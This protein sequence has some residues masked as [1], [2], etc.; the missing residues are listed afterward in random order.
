MSRSFRAE[1]AK[2][3]RRPATWLLLAI[4]LALSLIFTYLF[5]YAAVAGGTEGP[6]SDRGLPVL[7]P[8]HLVGNSLGG[9]PVFLGAIL[10]I[11]GVLTVGGE[12][13][14]GTWK[15]V[16]S[17]GPTRLEVYA[18]KLLALAAAAL[19]VVLAVFAVGAVSSLAI[20]SAEAQPVHW[21]T[22]GD[23]F[24]GLGAGWLIATMWAMLGAVLAVALRAVALP[25]GLG[26]VWML[27]VQNLLSA[28]A[29]PLLDW[30]AQAQKGLPGPNAG[31]LAAALGAPG[32][33]PGVAATVGGGQAA[34]VVA[35]YLVAFAAVGGVLL[36][37]RDI[38]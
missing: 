38:G 5:P 14:W 10:L 36:R 32:D 22:A 30:V 24:A 37:R 17:Q 20:A 31:A 29:A 33:T 7:L 21:P 15:T 18:G 19:A 3:V 6:N 28:I 4:T 9:L 27:A 26:L 25:V 34:L 13:G 2:L 16:L 23:L 12:Y 35:A 8:D 11:L 1:A